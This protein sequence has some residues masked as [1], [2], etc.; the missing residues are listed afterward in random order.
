MTYPSGGEGLHNLYSFSGT[1]S[2]ETHDWVVDQLPDLFLTTTKVKTQQAVKRWGHHC[3]DID[4]TGYLPNTVGPVTFVLDLRIVYD[5]VG[6]STDPTL[7][8]HLRYPNKLDP[9]SQKEETYSL[10]L[11]LY[12]LILT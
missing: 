11:N 8:G 2:Q 9:S 7:N 3:G 12:V 10:I 1:K 5:R 6:S 4:L